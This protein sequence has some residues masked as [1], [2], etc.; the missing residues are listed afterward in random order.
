[1]NRSVIV[2]IAVLTLCVWQHAVAK[3]N[4]L[5]GQKVEVEKGLLRMEV[6]VPLPATEIQPTKL[7]DNMHFHCTL[8]EWPCQPFQLL[9]GRT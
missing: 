8:S 9:I 4:A 6:S 7:I 1:M 3:E 2:V 5:T